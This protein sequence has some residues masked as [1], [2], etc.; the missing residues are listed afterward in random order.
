[1]SWRVW[2]YR[3]LP[4]L[5]R[6]QTEADLQEE[7]RFH[8][9][10][11]G[12]RN[13]DAGLPE[14]DAHRAPRRKVGNGT[15]IREGTRDVWRWRWLDDFVKD[16]HHAVRGLRRSPGF[17]AAVVLVLALGIGANTA[18]FSIARSTGGFGLL[19]SNLPKHRNDASTASLMRRWRGWRDF[20]TWRRSG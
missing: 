17:A 13:R 4:Y 18:M 7:L 14:E 19:C 2:L 16:A 9:K 20:R 11:E 1:M 3:V 15:L 10:L 12:E 5:G 8:L 6:R